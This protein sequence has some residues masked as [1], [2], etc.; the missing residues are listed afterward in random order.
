MNQTKNSKL[1]QKR[2]SAKKFFGLAVPSLKKSGSLFDWLVMFGCVLFASWLMFSSLSYQDGQFVMASKV[3]SDFGAHIP[4]IRSFSFGDNLPPEYPQFSGEPIRYHYGFY[5]LVGILEKLGINLALALNLVSTVG[6]S[7]LL[8]MI[9]QI[10]KLVAC[11][12][13][14]NKSFPSHK[15]RWVGALAVFLFL[16]N[17]SLTVIDF[18]R[19]NWQAGLWHQQLLLLTSK[20][21]NLKHFVNFG[22]WGGDT[23][24]AFWN[25]NIYT[26]QRHLGFSFGLVLLIIWPLLVAVYRRQNLLN[27]G[28]VL[29]IWFSLILLPFLHQAGYV[30]AV[31]MILGWLILHPHIIKTHGATYVLG[32]LYSFPGFSYYLSLQTDTVIWR[33]GYLAADPTLSSIWRYW[34]FNLGVYW[35]LLPV[36]L[37]KLKWV[38]KTLLL[39]FF[40]FFVLANTVQ[41]SADMINNHKLINFFMIGMVVLTAKLLV[42][43][44]QKGWW[45]KILAVILV[46]MMTASGVVDA[47]PVIN[48]HRVYLDDYPRQ[49]L[50]QWVLTNTDP[51]SVFLTTTYLYHPAL[52]AGRKT[53]LDYGYFAWSLGYADRQ[54]RQQL[55]KLFASQVEPKNWCQQVKQFG[56]DYVS[57]APGAGNLDLPVRSSWLVQTQ[58]PAYLSKQG[59][60]VYQVS[61]ICDKL[62]K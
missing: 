61:Q 58:Q 52:L 24:S 35:L 21:V 28:W 43:F 12:Q 26:N 4:L 53:F 60:K 32:I 16:F 37:V 50:S 38:N 19:Q 33:F 49:D 6:M 13:V 45:Q 10:G 59:Y 14:G 47:F 11:K 36:L 54:R 23:I 46:L 2:F 20:L 22:P 5:L 1:T 3:W 55:D 57:V 7:L 41:L 51:D 31:G 40:S 17:G 8:I 44:F 62:S 39:A 56:I 18:V 25:W 9:Y 42:D 30:I 27:T 15:Q 29:L 34:F 48:D